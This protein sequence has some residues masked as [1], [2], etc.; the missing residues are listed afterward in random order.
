ML[1]LFNKNMSLFIYVCTCLSFV[2]FNLV[3]SAF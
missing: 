3:N 1:V 2:V